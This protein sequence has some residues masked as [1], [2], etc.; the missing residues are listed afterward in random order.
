MTDHEQQRRRGQFPQ[1]GKGAQDI[2]GHE[3][4]SPN[5]PLAGAVLDVPEHDDG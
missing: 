2:W 4:A 3:I 5:G 1:R